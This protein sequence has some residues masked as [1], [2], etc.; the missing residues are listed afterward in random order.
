VLLRIKKIAVQFIL[1]LFRGNQRQWHSQCIERLVFLFQFSN[2]TSLASHATKP[3]TLDS[4]GNTIFR[5][6]LTYPLNHFNVFPQS[7]GKG[8]TFVLDFT[9]LKCFLQIL[10]Q[11]L[12]L[13]G[14]KQMGTLFFFFLLVVFLRM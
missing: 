12:Y 2:F 4:T 6:P 14:Q 3:Y 11:L 13:Q 10:R 9:N 1:L 8:F 5:V 7:R